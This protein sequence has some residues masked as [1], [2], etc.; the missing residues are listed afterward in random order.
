VRLFEL[1]G[2]RWFEAEVSP[3]GTFTFAHLA[4]GRYLLVVLQ[5]QKVLS[6]EL[7]SLKRMRCR[8]VEIDTRPALP[9]R[10]IE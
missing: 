7:L 9:F 6:T 2:T 5:A 1:Y 8:A 3:E 10:K 4:P